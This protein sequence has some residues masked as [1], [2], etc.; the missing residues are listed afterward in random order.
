MYV[1]VVTEK[2]NESERKLKSA[3]DSWIFFWE[4][5]PYH[6]IEE[7]WI[8]NFSAYLEVVLPLL[9]GQLSSSGHTQAA[10][11]LSKYRSSIPHVMW[12]SRELLDWQCQEGRDYVCLAH[13]QISRA[14]RGLAHSGSS[15]N[16]CGMV[17]TCG[18]LFQGKILRHHITASF[19]RQLLLR[20]QWGNQNF[21]QLLPY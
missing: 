10:F 4:G 17:N 20:S 14:S 6:H 5:P 21:H 15:T 18:D 12:P 13:C 1:Y 16:S 9:L 19:L 7:F 2:E 11:H 8:P 3:F